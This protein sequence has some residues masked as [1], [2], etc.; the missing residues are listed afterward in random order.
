MSISSSILNIMML[1]KRKLID[2]SFVKTI[3]TML[4]ISI[5]TAL[6]GYF[7]F[8]LLSKFFVVALFLSVA[9]TFAC[10]IC[11]ILL[12]NVADFKMVFIRKK[13]LFHKKTL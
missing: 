12:F 4:I 2:F 8:K 11:L 3:Y 10:T 9:L 5:L 7:V 1:N 13:K 6:V